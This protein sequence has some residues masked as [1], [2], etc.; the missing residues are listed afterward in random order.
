[1]KN[2]I[3]AMVT[4]VFLAVAVVV[5]PNT[6]DAADLSVPTGVHQTGATD[7]QVKLG[8]DAVPGADRYYW[9]WSRD[10]VSGWSDSNYDWSMKPEDTIYNLSAGATYYVRVRAADTSKWDD[11]KYGEWS[12]PVQVVT[13][14]DANQMGSLT[15]ADA[16]TTSLTIKWTPCP[17]ATAYQ[18]YDDKTLLGTVTDCAYVRSGLLPNTMYS[19]KVFPVRTSDSGYAASDNGRTLSGVYTKPNK[20]V[21]PSTVNFG[22]TNSYYNINV[23]YFGAN[24]PSN[25]ANGYEIEV[26]T[27]KGNKKVYT[28]TK[29][30][31]NRFVAKRNTAY[32]YRCRFYA[33]YG[34]EKIY[35]DW[36][37]YRYFLYQTVSGKRNGSRIKMSWKKVSNAK[38][39][40]VSISTKEKGGYK[41]VKTLGSKSTSLTIRKY[42]KK[43]LN[44]K[45]IYYVKVVANLK[46]GAKSVKSDT[47]YVGKAY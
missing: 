11:Y 14:P 9:A 45:T 3:K 7:D 37:G 36:S 34:E 13:A 22:L 4:F 20:P 16:T 31:L 17:G 47:Y 27:V 43:K 18:I 26:S 42:G 12:Q 39:Y 35:G 2:Y 5:L 10:G 21:K 23:A 8:W 25:T 44:R 29:S 38:S 15:L 46:D 28:A 40:T 6:A 19:V 1:M 32:K 30:T 33:T 24:D 41:K